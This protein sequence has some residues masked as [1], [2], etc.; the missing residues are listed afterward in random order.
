MSLEKLLNKAA[1]LTITPDEASSLAMRLAKLATQMDA[2]E[3]AE[4]A[5]I[6]GGVELREI[7]K[8]VADASDTDAVL[9]AEKRGG[10]DEVAAQIHGGV[11]PLSSNPE[12]RQ[13][14][15]DLRR[16]KDLI[17]DQVNADTSSAPTASP[18]AREPTNRSA[19]SASTLP[20]TAT[21]SPCCKSCTAARQDAPPT[22]NSKPSPSG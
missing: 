14:I 3:A 18:T 5:E 21:R 20:N 9:A 10:K 16:K 13:A 12:L 17:F 11:A 7:A 8:Q 1:N 4:L 15:L 2:A 19:R 22:P 6:A